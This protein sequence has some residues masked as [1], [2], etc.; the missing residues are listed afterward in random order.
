MMALVKP[1][2]CRYCGCEGDCRPS[3]GGD[4]V[5]GWLDTSHTVCRNTPCEKEFYKDDW[6]ARGKDFALIARS[7]RSKR[8]KRKK[9][10]AA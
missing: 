2:I 5:C 3:T 9:A 4:D 10:R 6:R 1:G 7:M 8:W